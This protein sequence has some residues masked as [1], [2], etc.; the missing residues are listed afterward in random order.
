MAGAALWVVAPQIA[1]AQT[2]TWLLGPN[3]RSGP[4]STV[5]PTDCVTGDDV[6]IT[7][8]TKIENSV[9]AS[10][11]IRKKTLDL[12]VFSEKSNNHAKNELLLFFF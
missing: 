2:V 6:S 4:G 5:V 1:Q 9:A 10:H 8:N 7:C 12:G 3:S 11:H